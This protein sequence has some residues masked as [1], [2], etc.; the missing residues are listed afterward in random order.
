MHVTLSI[1]DKTLLYP[2]M[3][4]TTIWNLKSI[5]SI[6]KWYV[7]IFLSLTVKWHVQRVNNSW[8]KNAR[9]MNLAVHDVSND[10]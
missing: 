7:Y 9:V 8:N 10:K 5:P 6:T 1:K 3:E 2:L 4:K